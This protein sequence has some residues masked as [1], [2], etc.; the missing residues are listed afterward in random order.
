MK[1]SR[2]APTVAAAAPPTPPRRR[3]RNWMLVLA[4]LAVLCAAGAYVLSAV[5]REEPPPGPAPEGMAWIPGGTFWMGAEDR[6]SPDGRPIHRLRVDGFW[7]DRTEV[8]NA[9]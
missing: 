3:S 1:K 7:M 6:D 4:G 8:T 5:L 9:Q 2:R